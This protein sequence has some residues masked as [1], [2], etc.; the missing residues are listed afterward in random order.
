M[1]S[2][3]FLLLNS[4]QLSD[5]FASTVSAF[6]ATKSVV[7]LLIYYYMVLLKINVF[8]ILTQINFDL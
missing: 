7:D 5:R 1:T 6:G 4:D 3:V 8:F 2:Y